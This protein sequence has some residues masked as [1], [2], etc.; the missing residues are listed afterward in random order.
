MLETLRFRILKLIASVQARS[1]YP[2]QIE[3]D[4][5]SLL[6]TK[7]KIRVAIIDDNN[8]PFSRALEEEGCY[9]QIFE[10]Y[11]TKVTQRNQKSK[12][13]DFSN[14]DIIVCDIHNIGAQIYPGSEG[15]SVIEDLRKKH[16]L[17]LIAA[18]TG[19]PGAIYT[20]LKKLS[21]LDKV[22]SKDW[23]VDDFLLNFRELL[24]V[25]VH[26]KSRWEFIQRRLS[27]L[28]LRQQKIDSIKRVFVENVLLCQMLS[29]HA[30]FNEKHLRQ[31]IVESNSKIDPRSV[32]NI[33]LKVAEV[34]QLI[35]PFLGESK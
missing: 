19:D 6:A 15:I 14:F 28:G 13:I 22:F 4:L 33:G 18:Y 10:D 20:K 35:I 31:V 9:V 17:K 29:K 24:D 16:P 25:F 21:S 8:F 1:T 2:E 11:S 5:L 27:H 26:P 30:H 23:V 7:P 34:G 3:L 12:V 32:I